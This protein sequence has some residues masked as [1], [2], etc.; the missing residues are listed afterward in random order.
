MSQTKRPV[1]LLFGHV[2]FLAVLVIHLQALSYDASYR[3]IMHINDIINKIPV[4]TSTLDIHRNSLST[5]PDS[6]LSTLTSLETL[7]ISYNR[8]SSISPT[9][10]QDTQLK[11]LSAPKNVLI[12]F[13]DL[14]VVSQTLIY[15]DLS[16][17]Q[18]VNIPCELLE[19]LVNLREL[20]LKANLL[21]IIPGT[22]S[23]VVLS[24]I[25]LSLPLK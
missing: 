15:L 16:S 20:R 9:C 6:A 19:P 8:L 12:M 1:G 17:N 10:F 18:I 25:E 21:T 11:I 13:P 7:T 3:N 2:V 4:A 22:C 23:Q 5:L 14:S 24:L